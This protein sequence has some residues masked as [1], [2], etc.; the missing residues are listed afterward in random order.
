MAAHDRRRTRDTGLE[1]A[2][3]SRKTRYKKPAKQGVR[4]IDRG[5]SLVKTRPGIHN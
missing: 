2:G 1:I 4:K 5:L 3:L